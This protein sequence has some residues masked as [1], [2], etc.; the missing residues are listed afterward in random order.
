MSNDLDKVLIFILYTCMYQTKNK[1]DFFCWNSLA[2]RLLK[3]FVMFSFVDILLSSPLHNKLCVHYR[4]NQTALFVA[5]CFPS[6]AAKI[7]IGWLK[8]HYPFRYH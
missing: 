7:S 4:R 5:L 2:A 6:K 3:E 8:C 1:I